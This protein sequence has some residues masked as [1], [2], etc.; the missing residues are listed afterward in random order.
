MTDEEREKFRPIVEKFAGVLEKGSADSSEV[1][2]LV[3]EIRK[4]NELIPKN[5]G[6]SIEGLISKISP[7]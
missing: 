5:I 1:A 7:V 3:K 4:L 6:T 2:I